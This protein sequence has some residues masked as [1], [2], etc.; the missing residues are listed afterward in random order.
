M[1]FQTTDV[2]YPLVT[3]KDMGCGV[4]Y[5]RIPRA[6]VIRPFDKAKH[7]RAFE[8]EVHRMTDEGLGGGNHFLSLEES[9]D[10]LYIIVHTGSRNLGVYMYQEN[11]RL[12]QLHNP[13]HEWLPTE[14]ATSTYRQEYQRVLAYAVSR[15]R[16]FVEKTYDFL[17]RN[18]YVAAG[19]PAFADSCHNLL[20]FGP[21]GV[22]HRKGS[23]Q[24]L[25]GGEVVIPLS[26]SRGSLIVKP[27]PWSTALEQSLWSCAHGAGRQYSRT[28]TLKVWH[29]LKKADKD[30]YRQRFSE[31]LNRQGDFDSSVLQEFDFAY[32]DTAAL[33]ATQP[34][35]IRCDETTPLVT[36]KFMGV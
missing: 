21:Q 6:D 1:A 32:K 4:A 28:D 10:Y 26:M 29:S 19:T 35:L 16:E 3:G 22:T 9:A 27:N 8:R 24:L 11:S 31:L 7:Y 18:Q 25:A 2:F 33:L 30:E 15:R 17:Q 20:E 14:L 36:V 23:T 5:L 34:H 12:L 13:G